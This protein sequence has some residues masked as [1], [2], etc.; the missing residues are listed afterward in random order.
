MS[1]LF[2]VLPLCLR[3]AY[4]V[5]MQEIFSREIFAIQERSP[6]K[7]LPDSRGFTLLELMV[8]VSI[9]SVLASVALPAYQDYAKRAQL[10]EIVLL[11]DSVNDAISIEHA[12]QGEFPFEVNGSKA[13]TAGRRMGIRVLRSEQRIRTPNSEMTTEYWYDF[14]PNSNRAWFGIGF[15]R[16]FVPGCTRRC[17]VHLGVAESSDGELHQFCGVWTRG[18]AGFPLELMPGT[19]QETCVFC[20]LT[21][22]R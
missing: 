1:C 7:T 6:M 20:R 4:H 14:D 9:I 5:D 15:R 22:I 13:M 19:C 11:V 3:V 16:E 21:A 10:T 8:V 2:G 18:W 12:V 17:V